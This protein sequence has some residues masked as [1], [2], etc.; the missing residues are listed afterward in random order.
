MPLVTAIEWDN[1]LNS[2]P[3]A[4]LLQTTAW[5]EFKASF[6]WRVFRVI[7]DQYGAQIL[8]RSLGLGFSLAYLPKGPVGLNSHDGLLQ[9]NSQAWEGLITELDI[10]CKQNRAVLLKVEPDIFDQ[11]NQH[12]VPPGFILSPHNIQP[13]RT[14]IVSLQGS[15][16]EILGRM[17]QKTRYNIR[18]SLKKGVI[19]RSS[20][21]LN[22]FHSLMEVT[23]QRDEFG[24]HS[25]DYYQH[26]YEIF[27]PRG[28]CELFVAEYQHKPLAA[29]MVFAHN[30]RA[31]YFYGASS[32]EHRDRMPNYL[33]QWE[34]MRWARDQGCFTY[35]LWGVPDFDLDTLESDFLQRSEGLWGVYRFKRGFGGQLYRAVNPWD[36]IYQT[37]IYKIYLWWATRKSN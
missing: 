29:L 21:D 5:G 7:S 6:G 3:G 32:D 19:V 36:R 23:G 28:K 11:S 13:L 8:I 26:A 2:Y 24:V 35:D 1:Y 15:E 17:K 4:H 12:A 18:L 34:A 14:L 37:V 20:A 10:L 27:Y 31:W 16:E 30:Q 25:R 22:L 9:I 33:L